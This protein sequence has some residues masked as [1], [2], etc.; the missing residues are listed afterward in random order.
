MFAAER[1][2]LISELVRSSGAVSLRDLA[3]LT[4]TSEVTVRR[5]LRHLEAE[6]LL[7]RRHGGAVAPESL[8]EPTHSEK[9]HV[10]AAEKAAIAA[11][12]AELV[13]D[14]DAIVLGAGTTTQ[15]LAR[16][17]TRKR[18]LTVVTN[19]LLVA[20]AL[21]RAPG[22]DVVM[23]GGSLRG[24]IYALV[25]GDAEHALSGL[26][27]STAF[28]SGNGLTAERGLSTPSM[29]VAGVD[30]AIAAAA[31]R[32]VV[33][34]DHTKVGIDTMVQ[35]VAT[36]RIDLLVTDTLAP[37]DEVAALREDDVEVT[38]VGPQGAAAID[39]VDA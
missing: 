17:L 11:A 5:D 14:G 32:V 8:Q 6:G 15:A 1:R 12:A 22:V 9:A 36:S 39:D 29:L 4:G 37:E 34:A 25:G 3:Q 13:E 27:V 19:S 30:R 31:R 10:A 2:R 28:M 26:R 24:S 23:T 21:A 20:Q 33:L 18:D 7:S 16:R 38:V 35:T